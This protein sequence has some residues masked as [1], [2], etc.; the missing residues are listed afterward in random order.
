MPHSTRKIALFEPNEELLFNALEGRELS[1]GL[2][3]FLLGLL[4]RK[5]W[6]RK[7][8]VPSGHNDAAAVL[9][10]TSVL[11]EAGLEISSELH[12]YLAGKVLIEK[13][14]VAGE[15]DRIALLPKEAFRAIDIEKVRVNG[16]LV[17]IEFSIPS[18]NGDGSTLHKTFDFSTV[19]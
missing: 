13:W 19:E 7:I 3:Q 12:V 16:S 5:K 9:I 18:A 6:P 11:K 10:F 2:R 14:Q 17:T 8:N 1:S 4:E 15:N